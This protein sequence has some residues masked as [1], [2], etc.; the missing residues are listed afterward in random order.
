MKTLRESI[1][2]PEFNGPELGLADLLDILP[3]TGTYVNNG[4]G[5]EMVTKP[6]SPFMELLSRAIGKVSKPIS[7]AK[8]ASLLK[9]GQSVAIEFRD[10][11]EPDCV[12]FEIVSRKIPN[13]PSNINYT[14]DIRITIY[15]YAPRRIIVR[16]GWCR[17][18]ELARNNIENCWQIP[19][20]EYADLLEY[21]KNNNAAKNPKGDASSS[22]ESVINAVRKR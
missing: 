6:D 15:A 12:G 9:A 14:P 2:D 3:K 17:D 20:K 18:S 22:I 13:S 21:I 7:R 1:L 16:T 10:K 5:F 8:V 4:V 11:Y 19:N